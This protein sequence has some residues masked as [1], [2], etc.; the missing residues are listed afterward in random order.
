MIHSSFFQP[1]IFPV[2]VGTPSSIARV[3]AI[4]PTANTNFQR[5]K[6]IGRL[7]TVGYVRH[8]PSVTYRMTQ[9]EYGSF[10]FWQQITN[11]PSDVTT[12]T[13]E[14]F[15]T[16]SFDMAAFLT[17]DNYQYRGV[18]LFPYMRTSGFSLN[19]GNPDATVERTF[20]FVGE[21]SVIF[22]APYGVSEANPY[23]TEV[24]KTCGTATDDIVDLSAYTALIDP[25]VP[26]T[27]PVAEQYIFRVALT[28]TIT[29]YDPNTNS[30]V[31]APITTVLSPVYQALNPAVQTPDYTYNTGTK[32]V[33]L[34]YG[35]EAG[36]VIKVWFIS[37][38]RPVE[39]TFVQDNTDIA[40]L[41]AT[42][43]DIFL[44]VPGSGEP[45]AGAY[46]YRIQSAAIDVT[47]ERADLKEIGNRNVVQLGINLNKVNIK[48]GRIMEKFTIDEVMRG[49]V[50]GYGKLDI[51]NYGFNMSL[52]VKM[53]EDDTKTNLLY[54]M[55]ATQ[56]APMDFS[57]G[58]P[59]N[60]YV[61][62]NAT[63]DG[64]FLLITTDNTQLGNFDG[65][66]PQ[67]N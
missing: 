20:N 43:T 5:V 24:D 41:N 33:T 1:E 63:L 55:Y 65:P 12:I 44:F 56:L 28:R 6:E 17:D 50:P 30:I 25:D 57:E 13:L 58:V 62:E 10:N 49:V 26:N 67:L 60:N 52:I 53:Y 34:N 40:G 64:E 38:N 61:K 8:I 15:K 37:S 45:N 14:D 7:Y 11:K 66:A 23:Y 47:F 46:L 19:I 27:F 18:K 54:G 59:V 9:I 39:G 21:K 36:D 2:G 51:E 16:T 4:D 29:A 22:E 42:A 31:S 32:Y 3:Q 48:L 35:V